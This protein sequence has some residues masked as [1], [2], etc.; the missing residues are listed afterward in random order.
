MSRYEQYQYDDD[1]F[2]DYESPRPIRLLPTLFAVISCF[3]I[4]FLPNCEEKSW[5]CMTICLVTSG[6][7][8]AAAGLRWSGTFGWKMDFFLGILWL[9]NAGIH[10]FLLIAL[11]LPKLE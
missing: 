5:A 9:L 7:Y 2:E 8:F 3:M 6:L 10:L 11:Y 4:L 1:D